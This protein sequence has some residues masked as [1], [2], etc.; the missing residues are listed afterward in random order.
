LGEPGMPE[1]LLWSLS[2]Q[3]HCTVSPGWIVTDEGEKDKSPPGA[4]VTMTVAPLA[5]VGQTARA[6]AILITPAARRTEEVFIASSK[7]TRT[8]KD[9]R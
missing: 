1:V 6:A 7:A 4:T 9:L 2:S 3:F 5:M 8:M